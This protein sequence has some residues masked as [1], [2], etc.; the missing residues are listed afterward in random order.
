[1]ASDVLGDNM[2]IHAGG[3]DLRFPHHDNELAQSEACHGCHQWVNYFL[4]AGHLN[5]RGLKMSKSLK[6]F[7]TIRQ[8][9]AEHSPRQL[10]LMF[11]LQPWDRAMYYSDQVMGDAKAKEALFKNFFGAIKAALRDDAT[12]SD[13]PCGWRQEDKDLAAALDHATSRTHAALCDNFDTPGALAALGTYVGAGPLRSLG[14]R[15]VVDGII[16]C[17]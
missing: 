1:M 12:G 11:L 16:A 8:A 15:H 5:I 10:R 9:L 17:M 6:N 7:V 4:H 14:A 13:A 3:S 2:D